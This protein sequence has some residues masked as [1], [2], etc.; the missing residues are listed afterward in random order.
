[1]TASTDELRNVLGSMGGLGRLKNSSTFDQGR[2]MAGADSSRA[3]VRLLRPA[4]TGDDHL[5]KSFAG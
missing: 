2:M 4:L 5:S 3:P 1:M